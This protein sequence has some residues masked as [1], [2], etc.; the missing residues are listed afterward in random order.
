MEP[1]VPAAAQTDQSERAEQSDQVS[2]AGQQLGPRLVRKIVC[3][4]QPGIMPGEWLQTWRRLDRLLDR[5][6]FKVKAV[7]E[8][9]D[10][11]PADVDLVVIEPGLRDAA[12]AILQPGIPVLVTSSSAAADAFAELVR[13]LEAGD[14]LTAERKSPSEAAG[15]T[16]VTY[17]GG[18]R[19]D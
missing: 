11:L 15:P 17:R 12:E 9:L 1:D 7:L 13:Q 18:Q 4:Y 5:S 8:P 19:I 6:G 16:I 14:E 10:D 2:Q 3:A